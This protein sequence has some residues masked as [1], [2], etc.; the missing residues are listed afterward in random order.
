MFFPKLKNG[1]SS[2]KSAFPSKVEDCV[3]TT[4]YCRVVQI[5][6][7][8]PREVAGGMNF[9][10][11]LQGVIAFANDVIDLLESWD[12]TLRKSFLVGDEEIQSS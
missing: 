1:F 6:G 7:R 4:W 12:V 9:A 11:D 8:K 2:L 5:T 3:L 10:E